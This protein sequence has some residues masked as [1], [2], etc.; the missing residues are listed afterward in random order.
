MY[1]HTLD[2][3]IIDPSKKPA[4]DIIL[5]NTN[6]ENL[7]LQKNYQLYQSLLQFTKFCKQCD[8]NECIGGY[9]CDHGVCNK[10]FQICQDDLN[11][12]N[13]SISS[14][15]LIHLTSRKLKPWFLKKQDSANFSKDFSVKGTLLNDM[16]FSSLVVDNA[17]DESISDFAN[18][19]DEENIIEDE[20]D[21]SIF[22]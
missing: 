18:S 16:F 19:S 11:Y 4:W 8:K 6:L 21:K 20:C 13:C 22:L 10:K 12:G 2:E 14:C 17:D 1:A 15:N 9:N 3:Q 7:D 5:S